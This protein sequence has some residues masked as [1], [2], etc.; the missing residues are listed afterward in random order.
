M[1]PLYWNKVKAALLFQVARGHRLRLEREDI[2]DYLAL[3]RTSVLPRTLAFASRSWK[4]RLCDGASARLLEREVLQ[5]WVRS[6][7]LRAR[8]LQVRRSTH[9][10]QRVGRTSCTQPRPRDAHHKH[11][12]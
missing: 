7:Q 4:P 5:A 12:S 8:F 10:I 1:N 3:K 11:G 9:L 6:M 2:V